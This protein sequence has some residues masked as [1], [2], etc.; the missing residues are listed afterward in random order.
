MYQ[1]QVSHY[2]QFPVEIVV[3]IIRQKKKDG[4]G[5]LLTLQT[6]TLLIKSI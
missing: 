4:H 3:I 1:R 5:K 6:T 2:F